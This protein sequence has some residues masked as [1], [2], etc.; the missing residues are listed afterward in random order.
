MRK[1]LLE[2]VDV[3]L[4]LIVELLVQQRILFVGQLRSVPGPEL[5]TVETMD[6]FHKIVLEVLPIEEM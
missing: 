4:G 2:M 1:K 6:H 3:R 5:G